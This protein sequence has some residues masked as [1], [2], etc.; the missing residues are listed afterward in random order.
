MTQPGTT[1][2]GVN[3]TPAVQ[4][5]VRDAFGNQVRNAPTQVTIAIGNNPGN[6]TL[7]GTTTVTTT[8]GV[9]TFDNLTLDRLGSGY[10]LTAHATGLTDAGSVAFDVTPGPASR[11]A[12]AQQPTSIVEGNPFTPE[13]I[14]EV[15]D[16]F[17]NRVTTAGGS[18]TL[19]VRNGT[20]GGAPSN[21]S[22]TGGG[23]RAFVAGA[24]TFSG[25]TVNVSIARTLTLRATSSGFPNVLSSPFLVTPFF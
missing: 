13:V 9:A 24:A 23:E 22:L 15:Q 14:V 16:Q 25:M 5:L 6:A 12:F 1:G 18:V 19:T 21:T 2:A 8:A 10:T 7:G 3:I 20:G 17:G 4:V 11:I